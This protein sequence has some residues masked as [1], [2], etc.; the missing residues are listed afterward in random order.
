MTC[1]VRIRVRLLVTCMPI[2]CAN[3]FQ[4]QC[5]LYLE[6]GSIGEKED[7]TMC[8]QFKSEGQVINSN[9]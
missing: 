1:R 2:H 9:E 8:T 7:N 3:W 5:S 6:C 4:P